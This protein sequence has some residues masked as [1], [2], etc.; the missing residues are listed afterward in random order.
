MRSRRTRGHSLRERPFYKDDEIERICEDSLR[1]VS[2]MPDLPSPVRID[3]FIEKKFGVA[4]TYE[5]LPDGIL[6]FTAFGTKGVQ[7]VCVS[8]SLDDGGKV[9][10]R[11][12]RSTLAHEGGHGLLHA[13]LF[14]LQDCKPLFGDA[15]DP[16][17][18]KV[19]CR[20]EAAGGTTGPGYD[21]RW[22][23]FQA[24]SAMGCLLL[25]KVLV[26]R[27]LEPYFVSRGLLGLKN[28]DPDR[29][30]EASRETSE[31]F[32]VNPVV[33]KLRLERLFPAA[34]DRQLT[35]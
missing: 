25:P 20:D 14:G 21:G 3:R 11:R 5:D 23:E 31:V 2:L 28:L 1:S 16:T 34:S 13:H 30:N 27:V 9:G 17:K 4:P 29:R 19:M 26:E 24:N 32:N 12:V 10:E 22:W 7:A 18:P 8:R 33:A 6:G 15:S 35:L